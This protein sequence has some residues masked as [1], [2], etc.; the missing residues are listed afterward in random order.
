[1][2]AAP[3]GLPGGFLLEPRIF[4]DRRGF[5]LESF[6]QRRFA[7]L[8]GR[9]PY[10]VQDNR[11]GSVL[12]VLRG[13]HFQT[14]TP[15][16]KLIW[17]TAGAVFDVAVDLR[18]D[19]PAFGRWTGV[20]LSAENKKMLWLPEGLAHGFLALSD[21]AE[22]AY[23]V[24]AYYAPENERALRWD[25]PT[26]NVAWPLPPGAEPILSDKDRRGLSWAEAVAEGGLTAGVNPAGGRPL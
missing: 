26:V 18:P 12:H 11:S 13:L 2:K 10:F 17:A 22:I 16:A 23:K 15:Q 1:M 20:E 24:N 3:L 6:N 25:D 19:S 5:F 9:E 14:R 7:E 21:W 8:T 4:E